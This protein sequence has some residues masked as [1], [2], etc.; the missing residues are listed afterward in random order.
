MWLSIW[1]MVKYYFRYC[2]FNKYRKSFFFFTL[3]LTPNLVD[4]VSV[5]ENKIFK[6]DI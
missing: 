3:Y 2:V 1:N 5:D 4:T 6:N